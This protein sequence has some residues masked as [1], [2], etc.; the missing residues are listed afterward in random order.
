MKEVQQLQLRGVALILAVLG[1]F[2]LLLG[3]L[4]RLQVLGGE[5]WQDRSQ[6]NTIRAET[7]PAHRG[8]I[9][10]RRGRVLVDNRPSYSVTGVPAQLSQD[11][12]LVRAIAERCGRDE[13]LL[14]RRIDQ[15][16]RWR[17][18][19][20][21]LLRGVSFEERVWL[22]E[23]RFELPSVELG[24]EAARAYPRPVAPHALGYL[25][26]ISPEELDRALFPGVL[27]GELVG[28]K[29]IERAYDEILR[30]KSG[31][32]FYSVDARGR[33]LGPAS[34]LPEIPA[35]H[36]WNLRLGLDLELQQLAQNLLGERRGAALLMDLQSGALLVAHSSPTIELEHFSG[37]M[38]PEVW[39]RLSDEETRPML[40]RLVQG[41][42]PPGSLFKIAVTA[43]ALEKGLVT[44]NTTHDCK[45][46]ITLGTRTQRCWLEEGHGP[47]DLVQ[48]IQHSCDVWYYRLGLRLSPDQIREMAE[49]FLLTQITGV[50]LLG[51]KSGLVP[52]TD[53]YDTHLG[54]RG[55]TLGVML[56]LAIGQGEILNTPMQ[57]LRFAALVAG[58]G[59]C[60]TPH[61]VTQLEHPVSGEVRRLEYPRQQV[62]FSERTWRTLQ[63]SCRA[64]VQ[65]K[66]G[67]AYPMRRAEYR[68]AGKTGTSENPHGEPHSIYMGW[69]PEDKPRIA[70]LVL[71][72]NAGHGS[73]VAAPICFQLFDAW[74]ELEMGR[75]VLQPESAAWAP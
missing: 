47:M 6:R 60:V 30:G 49:S 65:E 46:S 33:V 57:M 56:N 32:R 58:R 61:F 2:L 27:S 50:D 23:H 53:W 39:E 12:S 63:R 21:A 22:A 55:W 40:N 17:Q 14:F 31:Q 8:L 51:E 42:Y 36:G 41:T 43:W 73:E 67:T 28:K 16:G 15:A 20:V 11:S 7:I 19:P 10:D 3:Q 64:V 18:H 1:G 9:L 75:V 71:V 74:L 25:G 54:R 35:D 45:G 52:D 26:E 37:R 66:G 29:G 69:M 72:E 38:P 34:Q 68:S 5:D 13:Q 70:G 48:S 62:Q 24:I 44:E 4:F 59:E